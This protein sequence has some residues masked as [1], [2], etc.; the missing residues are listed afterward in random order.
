MRN[1]DGNKFKI[2]ELELQSPVVLAPMAGVTDKAFRRVC[3]DYDVGLMVTE[4]VSAKALYY[5]DKK[6][7]RIMDI[8]EY[9]RPVALQIFGCEAQLMADV[10][11]SLNNHNHDIIDINMGCPAPKITKN[12]EGSALMKEP[13]RVYDIIKAVSLAS[14]KPTTVKIR[15]GWDI[16]SVNAVDIAKIAEDAGASAVSIHGRTRSQFYS[17]V[18]DWDIIRDVKRSVN[19]PIVGNGDVF[20]IED[21]IKLKEHTD[22]DGIM[23]GRGAQ[24]NP[25]L[26]K[27]VAHYLKTGKILPEPSVEEKINQALI[28]FEYLIS[29][30]G[31]YIA[32]LEMRKHAAWY[33]KGLYGASKV[34]NSINQSTDVDEIRQM[35]YSLV[36]S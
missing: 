5:G 29:S 31:E 23:I 33:I 19:I 10:V 3:A 8:A 32:M 20:S 35:L 4:M 25:W 1:A 28:H 11:L 7:S 34:K 36:S 2:G 16:N 15:K 24:G 21:A 17:G 27:K 6:T 9:E 26:L 14:D 30:K 22:C 12:G 18:A 13:N